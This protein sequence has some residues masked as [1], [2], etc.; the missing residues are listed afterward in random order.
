MRK[1]LY[2]LPLMFLF[3]ACEVEFSPNASWKNIPAVY[4]L[5]DQDDDTTWVRVQRCYLTEGNIF[6]YGQVSDSIN[7]PQGSI[8]VSL[9]AY[10]NGVL[11][12]SMAFNYVER[13]CDSGVFANTAQPLYWFETA[14]RLK[15]NYSYVL[16][17]RNA[18]DGSILATTDPLS[19]IKKTSESLIT[20]PAV[21]VLNGHDTV[22]GGFAFYDNLGTSSTTIYCHIKWN[23]LENARLYQPI[24]RFYYEV[25]GVLKHVDLKCPAVSSKYNETYYSRDLFLNELKQQLQADTS[26]KRYI[27][28]VDM[29]LTSCSEDLNAYLSTVASGSSLSQNTEVYN[30]IKGGVGIFA[31]RRTHLFKRMP[32]DDGVGPRGLLSYLVELGVGIY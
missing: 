17:V 29:Y 21:T 13:N 20:K 8:T 9:L 25:Q 15:E 11:K 18:A 27:P 12:D 26:R 28:R 31:A 30:N 7:Y 19:L 14:N 4:C 24:V 23:P 6:N 16:T 32:S 1:V 2:F 10:E 5:L 22:G 3:A